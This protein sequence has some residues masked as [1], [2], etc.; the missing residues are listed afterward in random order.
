MLRDWSSK[1]T[2]AQ[3]FTRDK[4]T[5]WLLD[6]E[7][8][9]LVLVITST[10][11]GETLERWTFNV[12]KEERPVLKDGRYSW[13]FYRENTSDEASGEF[14]IPPTLNILR[15]LHVFTNVLFEQEQR[16]ALLVVHVHLRRCNGW[17]MTHTPAIQ[18][19]TLVRKLRE[20]NF[21]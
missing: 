9:R 1:L 10:D 7:L 12:H 3:R 19:C 14:T 2:L 16:I 11:S 21:L 8:Q 15:Y 18:T 20:S 4:R 6:S 13:F 17:R 5:A